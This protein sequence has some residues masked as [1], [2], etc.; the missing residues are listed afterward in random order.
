[1]RIDYPASS[2]SDHVRFI[3]GDHFGWDDKAAWRD[4]FGFYLYIDDI[5]NLD[6]EYGYF[7]LG[8]YDYTNAANPVIHRWNL[9]TFSGVLQSGWNNLSLT[10]LYADDIIYTPLSDESG[11]DPR[12]LYSI[13]WGTMGFVYRGKGE[14]LR[15]NF[16]GFFI[17]RN[18]FEHTCFPG[19]K[20]LYINANDIFKVPIG[21]LDFHA[22]TLEF[23]LRPDWNWDGRD[24][25]GDFRFRALFHFGNVANDVLGAVVSDRGLEIYY[26]NLLK[27][28]NLFIINGFNF[29]AIDKLT[30][31]AFVFSNDGTGMGFDNSTIRLYVNNELMAKSYDTWEVNDDKYFNFMLGGQGLLVEKTQGFDPNSDAVDAVVCRLKLHNYC[32]TDFSDSMPDYNGTFSKKLLK[33]NNFIEISSDNVTY[34]KVGSADLPFFFENVPAGG[35]IPIWVKVH[36]PKGLTGHEKRTAE[37]IGSW[38][39]G[40]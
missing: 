8:G 28:F 6:L 34:H 15:L 19:Q 33:P 26:G 37:L 31:L 12:R 13:K 20:G 9:T 21:E 24:H 32:K 36:V 16:E 11:R 10:F 35:S 5:N 1:L 2:E 17:E 22:S 25:Y 40:V 23:F 38:D 7:Y 4:G 14:P 39:I 18:Y 29:D 30:H 3:E 27:D